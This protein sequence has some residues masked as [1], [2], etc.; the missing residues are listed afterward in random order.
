MDESQLFMIMLC[1]FFIHIQSEYPMNANRAI[2]PHTIGNS[3]DFV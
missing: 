2:A 3:M 1:G